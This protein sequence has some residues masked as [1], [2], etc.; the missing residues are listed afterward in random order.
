MWVCIYINI[1]VCQEYINMSCQYG[2][3]CK[4]IV[5]MITG[6][7]QTHLWKVAREKGMKKIVRGAFKFNML[8]IT[9]V[10]HNAHFI[11]G[12]ATLLWSYT[13]T[14]CWSQGRQGR[15]SSQVTICGNIRRIHACAD[16]AQQDEKGAQLYTHA[17]YISNNDAEHSHFS[18][19]LT[20]FAT[21]L[22]SENWRCSLRWSSTVEI[23]SNSQV[24]N[25]MIW[26]APRLE[27]FLFSLFSLRTVYR[28]Q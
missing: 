24:M 6:L 20:C 13:R 18:W 9:H 8:A 28:Y 23:I 11:I 1:L 14:I 12:C 27:A 10:G 4:M 22:S 3:L 7:K 2:K 21:S 26:S 17:D 16:R 19:M 15:K 25:N 5:T